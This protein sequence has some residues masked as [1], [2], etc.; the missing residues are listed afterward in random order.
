MEHV[1]ENNEKQS[2][3]PIMCK[4]RILI[5]KPIDLKANSIEVSVE[6]KI[7]SFLIFKKGIAK[8]SIKYERDTYYPTEDAKAQ[9]IIDNSECEKDVERVKLK[10]VRQVIGSLTKSYRF[11]LKDKLMHVSY[12]GFKAGETKEQELHLPLE[13]LNDKTA[14][15]YIKYRQSQ[16]K[17]FYQEDKELLS[18][19]M[20]TIGSSLVGCQCTLIVTIKHAGLAT[21]SKLE[22][23]KL[24]LIIVSDQRFLNSQNQVPSIEIPEGWNPRVYKESLCSCDGSVMS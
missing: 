20:P 22:P 5:L 16:K 10:L 13:Y 12:P 23:I 3:K 17:E 9:L 14:A 7:K 11:K 15:L 6:S 2:F 24:P 18:H 19:M 21:S 4:K 1:P 8:A